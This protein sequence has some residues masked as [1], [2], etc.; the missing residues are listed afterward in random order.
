[1]FAVEDLLPS[2]ATA[3]VARWKLNVWQIGASHE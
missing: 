1:M 3:R 2:I